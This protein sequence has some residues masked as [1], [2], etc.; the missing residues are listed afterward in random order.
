MSDQRIRP[1]QAY[2]VGVTLSVGV[3]VYVSATSRDD[4]QRLAESA[5]AGLGHECTSAA[6]RQAVYVLG[7]HPTSFC[8]RE[9]D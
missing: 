4:A 7:A 9:A 3:E 6:T 8:V 2:C 1:L 5:L